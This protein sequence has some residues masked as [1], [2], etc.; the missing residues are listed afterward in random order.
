MSHDAAWWRLELAYYLAARFDLAKTASPPGVDLIE[1]K[2]FAVGNGYALP[3][4]SKR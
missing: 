4:P 2:E 1:L 3:T